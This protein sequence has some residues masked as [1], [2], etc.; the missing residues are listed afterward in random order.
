VSVRTFDCVLASGR[1]GVSYTGASAV[2]AGSRETFSVAVTADFPLRPGALLGLA[3]LAE[4][5]AFP[6]RT[7]RRGRLPARGRA[8][9]MLRWWF[10]CQHLWHPFD[11]VLF[12]SLS[13]RG[14]PRASRLP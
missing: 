11:H 2:T 6:S 3:A 7:I 9:R 14:W 13:P 8:G 5:W 10:A 12:V 1:V 4:R